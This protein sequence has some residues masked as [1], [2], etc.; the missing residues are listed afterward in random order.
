MTLINSLI[1]STTPAPPK[2]IVYGHPPARPLGGGQLAERIE[3][4]IVGIDPFAHDAPGLLDEA[5][6][7]RP[8]L[9][10]GAG[11]RWAVVVVHPAHAVCARFVH[12]CFHR[13][14]PLP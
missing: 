9:V 8:L 12:Y 14:T 10:A 1:K 5:L 11:Q 4:I 2:M 6:A 13:G 3:T 7:I